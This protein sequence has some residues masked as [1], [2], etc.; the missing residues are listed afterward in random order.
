MAWPT[1]EVTLH[2]DGRAESRLAGAS[3]FPRHWL[4]DA[5]GALIAKS[6][7]TDWKE[8]TVSAFGKGTPWGDEDSPAFVTEVE[9]AL[10]RER[11]GC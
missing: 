1:L 3:P 6:G 7:I 8:W 9:T 11:Q 10:E 5:D 4:Y 2:A